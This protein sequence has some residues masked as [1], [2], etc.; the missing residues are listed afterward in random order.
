MG[1]MQRN[2]YL[3]EEIATRLFKEQGM[4]KSIN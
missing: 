4:K 2:T 1:Q 3:K